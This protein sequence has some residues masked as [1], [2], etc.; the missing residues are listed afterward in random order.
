[1]GLELPQVT[2]C[3]VDCVRPALAA[4]ALRRSQQA[5][6]FGDALLLTDAPLADPEFRTG[7]IDPLGSLDAYSHFVFKK[8]VDWIETDFVLLVQWDGF[9]VE[10][11]A[12]RDEFLGHDYVGARWRHFG[13]DMTVGNGGFSLRSRRLLQAVAS[14][15]FA[16]VE[17][18]LEDVLLCRT[19]R[20]RLVAEHGIRYAPESVAQAFSYEY[21]H[22]E[23]PSFGFHGI[24]NLWRHLDDEEV[25][26]LAGQLD[27]RVLGSWQFLALLAHYLAAGKYRMA[28]RLH[29]AVGQHLDEAQ[30]RRLMID[31][32]MWT[33]TQGTDWHERLLRLEAWPALRGTTSARLRT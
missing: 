17:G 19:Y 14:D 26:A 20:P 27:G 28:A 33:R 18:A 15:R 25:A 22:P 21:E 4:R 24:T 23:Q 16:W 9:V 10:P 29:Q 8:L 11:A 7:R 5:C 31:H 1:M 30:L 12:W 32:P 3:A 13:D 6:R 2:L